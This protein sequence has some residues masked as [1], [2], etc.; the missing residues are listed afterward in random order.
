MKHVKRN[1][2]LF[3]AVAAL[4]MAPAATAMAAEYQTPA[5][6]AAEVTG[7][8]VEDVARERFET[9]KTYGAIA[10]EDGRLDEFKARRLDM[11]EA[12]L[13]EQAEQGIISQE[14]MDRILSGIKARQAVCDGTGYGDGYG[15]QYLAVAR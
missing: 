12:V 11:Q 6:T 2:L 3:T 9:G 15:C 13:S 1:L 5:D 4:S 8:S 10:A 7:R 14:E